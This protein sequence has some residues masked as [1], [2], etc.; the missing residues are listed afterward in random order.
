MF[1]YLILLLIIGCGKIPSIQKGYTT[2]RLQDIIGEFEQDFDLNVNYSVKFVKI[3]TNIPVKNQIGVCAR[4][5]Y[6]NYVEILYTYENNQLLD[7]IVYH[8]LGHCSLNLGHYNSVKDIMNSSLTPQL[9]TNFIFYR[10]Q[11]LINYFTFI[12][13]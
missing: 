11:M 6:F 1:K 5:E 2:Q 7:P 4:N 3:F 13:P 8:E 12:Y 9:G 10:D